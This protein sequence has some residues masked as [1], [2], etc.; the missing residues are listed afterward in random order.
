VRLAALAAVALLAGCS[1]TQELVDIQKVIPR[2][3]L[4]I[5]YA[6]PDNFTR[7]KVYDQAACFLRPAT[8][9]RLSRA[10]AE[11]EREG[12]GLKVYDCYRPL[13]V[14]RRFWAL[15]PDERFVANPEQGSN[16][17]RGAAVDLTL[18]DAK[19]NELP[20]PTGFDD[21][22]ELAHR[23]YSYLPENV[24]RNR[25][26]LARAMVNQGFLPLPT[27]WWHFDDPECA[28]YSILNLP[29]S[30]LR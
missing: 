29:F 16:H 5:R 19:G 25:E 3:R 8:A 17:N 28:H 20:M 12:L 21:F 18:V 15:V 13:A 24:I 23:S 4:D 30:Q 10:Q 11:L 7:Q 6:T 26:R 22:T 2:I 14:Q 1:R 9:A 27:E